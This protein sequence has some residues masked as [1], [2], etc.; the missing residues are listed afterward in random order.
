M[1][2]LHTWTARR[3]LALLGAGIAPPRTVMRA[4]VFSNSTQ[5]RSCADWPL[6]G[7]ALAGAFCRWGFGGWRALSRG[8]RGVRGAREALRREPWTSGEPWIGV[9]CV[10]PWGHPGGQAQGGRGSASR[11]P[12]WAPASGTCLAWGGAAGTT[13]KQREPLEA[14]QR[15]A[16]PNK[17]TTNNNNNNNKANN[18]A[19]GWVD[20]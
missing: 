8:L 7:R 14:A 1:W 13:A 16:V 9:T 10:T 15:S 5:R 18:K 3:P 11:L 6:T 2:A 17:A 4:G 12:A 20:G 19:G